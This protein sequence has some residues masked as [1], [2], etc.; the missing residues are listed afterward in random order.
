MLICP[1]DFIGRWTVALEERPNSCHEQMDRFFGIQVFVQY[2]PTRVVPYLNASSVVLREMLPPT[3]DSWD[4]K[5][6]AENHVASSPKK[7]MHNKHPMEKLLFRRWRL[8]IPQGTA[9]VFLVPNVEFGDWW[10]ANVACCLWS[11]SQHKFVSKSNL[12]EGERV[13]GTLRLCFLRCHEFHC[14]AWT[15]QELDNF[16]WCV[17]YLGL[18]SWYPTTLCRAALQLAASRKFV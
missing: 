14:F 18:V 13:G 2:I 4:W 1:R 5:F 16:G 17:L 6:D 12:L 10:A 9:I 7:K 3:S 8:A 15:G 11:C